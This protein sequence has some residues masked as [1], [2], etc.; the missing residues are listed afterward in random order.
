MTCKIEFSL[1]KLTF[2]P[3]RSGLKRIINSRIFR[4]NFSLAH[5][6]IYADII[7]INLRKLTFIDF[8]NK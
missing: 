7:I 2:N 1:R 4:I 6:S 5:R 8:Y 3:A